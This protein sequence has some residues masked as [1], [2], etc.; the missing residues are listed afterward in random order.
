MARVILVVLSVTTVFAGALS[1]QAAPSALAAAAP[2]TRQVFAAESSFAA[3][4]ANRDPIAFG[5]FVAPEA[6]F[7]G[8]SSVM[9]G[10]TAVLDGWRAFFVEPSAPF[11][12]KPE[13]VEV[14]ASGTL[15]HSSGPVHNAEGRLIGTFNSIWRREPDGTW[16]V[17]FDKGSPVCDCEKPGP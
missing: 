11:S 1:G 14:V 15:A 13:T 5:R 4:M 7:F 6:V 8:R 9:R 3:T 2:L 17:V 16:L 10:K 12:W